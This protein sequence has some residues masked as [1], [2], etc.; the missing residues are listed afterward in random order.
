MST[1]STVKVHT[2]TCREC[3]YRGILEVPEEGYHRWF[4]GGQL[5]QVALPDLS[6]PQR[7]QLI[8]GYHPECWEDLFGDLDD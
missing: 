2:K 4:F 3:G 5:I 8:S 7:E 1:I 6:A